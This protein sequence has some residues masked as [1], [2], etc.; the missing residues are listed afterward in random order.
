[1]SRFGVALTGLVLAAS[2]LACSSTSSP[3]AAAGPGEV[4][5]YGLE[6][7]L[8]AYAP[9]PGVFKIKVV[10]TTVSGGFGRGRMAG[11]PAPSSLKEGDTVD[12]EVVPEGS[13]LTRTVIMGP[14]G[15]G[16]DDS[17]TKAGFAEAVE[18][19]PRDRPVVISFEPS[20]KA[21]PSPW[22]VRMVHVRLSSIEME[23]RL[24]AMGL[25]PNQPPGS[26]N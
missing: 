19:I 9:D 21:T 4:R 1:M 25:D 11:E 26:S 22:V 18:V 2:L 13:V 23:K 7:I 15:Q 12:F 17:G 16:L 6:G 10:D 14:N 5:R 8:V 24:R 20:G 3:P